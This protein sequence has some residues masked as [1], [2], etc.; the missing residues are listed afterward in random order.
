[1]DSENPEEEAHS[2]PKDYSAFDSVDTASD[3]GLT[4]LLAVPFC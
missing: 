3:D 1:M 4:D 2:Y